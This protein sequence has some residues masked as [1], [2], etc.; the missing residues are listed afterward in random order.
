MIWGDGEGGFLCGGVDG[1]V[2]GWV[3]GGG[4]GVVWGWGRVTVG[5]EESHGGGGGEARGGGRWGT[6]EGGVGKECRTGGSPWL[7]ANRH[8]ACA[9]SWTVILVITSTQRR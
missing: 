4:G 5:V 7:V 6:D 9:L 8:G 3:C 2:V 1:R